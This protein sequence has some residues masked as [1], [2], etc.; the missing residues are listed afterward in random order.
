MGPRGNCLLQPL[1]PLSS[2]S[3]LEVHFDLLDLTE[4]TAMSD[5]ELAEV[6]A[7]SDDEN[8]ATESP[9]GELHTGLRE[10][11]RIGGGLGESWGPLIMC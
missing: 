11:E 9:A 5:Q 4:L 2:V 7:D 8:L 3:S 1:E 10:R 6:F